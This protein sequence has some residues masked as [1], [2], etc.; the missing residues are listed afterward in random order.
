[1]ILY[2]FVVQQT[3]EQISAFYP[4]GECPD[5]IITKQGKIAK[6]KLSC[7]NISWGKGA[8]PS[9]IV[10]RK[11]KIMTDKNNQ[12]GKKGQ[13]YWRNKMPKLKKD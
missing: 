9:S 11:R 1:M 6:R 3:G 8:L 10:Q 13:E 2:G 7:P 12:S 5:Q 4:M